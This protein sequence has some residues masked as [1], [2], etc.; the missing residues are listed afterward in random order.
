MHEFRNYADI[1]K[2]NVNNRRLIFYCDLCHL[3]LGSKD[4][5]CVSHCADYLHLF[6]YTVN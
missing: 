1:D 2:Y 6:K 3:E 4:F 5:E